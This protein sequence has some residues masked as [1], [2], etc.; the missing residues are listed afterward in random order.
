[1]NLKRLINFSDNKIFN[2]WNNYIERYHLIKY[3]LPS[4]DIEDLDILKN[5]FEIIE[6][7]D[8]KEIIISIP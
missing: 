3:I 8:F 1:M 7:Y 6:Q 5:N 4:E 2:D